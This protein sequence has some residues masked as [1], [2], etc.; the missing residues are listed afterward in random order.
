MSMDI[1]EVPGHDVEKRQFDLQYTPEMLEGV[2]SYVNFLTGAALERL[3]NTDTPLIIRLNNP[4]SESLPGQERGLVVIHSGNVLPIPDNLAPIFKES[5]LYNGKLLHEIEIL[6]DNLPLFNDKIWNFLYPEGLDVNKVQNFKLGTREL[7]FGENEFA[8]LLQIKAVYE[9]AVRNLSNGEL[10]LNTIYITKDGRRAVLVRPRE[11]QLID[12]KIGKRY[13]NDT[14]AMLVDIESGERISEI[15]GKWHM[16][17]WGEQWGTPFS[18]D[19]LLDGPSNSGTIIFQFKIPSELNVTVADFA[20]WDPNLNE[21]GILQASALS[22]LLHSRFPS[23]PDKNSC[24]NELGQEEALIG[25]AVGTNTF[26]PEASYEDTIRICTESAGIAVFNN[27]VGE[28]TKDPTSI[29]KIVDPKLRRNV[30]SAVWYRNQGVE[31]PKSGQMYG[32]VFNYREVDFSSL[33]NNSE[34]KYTED[35][36]R[37]RLEWLPGGEILPGTSPARYYR[38]KIDYHNRKTC[39]TFNFGPKDNVVRFVDLPSDLIPPKIEFKDI[40]SLVDLTTARGTSIVCLMNGEGLPVAKW[41]TD[42]RYWV[43]MEELPGIFIGAKK[44][45]S[46]ITSELIEMFLLQNQTEM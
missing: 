30:L 41:D 6:P 7:P 23:V 8:R 32:V 21:K 5:S 43:P 22:M 3:R 10:T 44:I 13:S 27:F 16:E 35:A 2:K 31:E 1:G 26:V 40:S 25:L 46:Q 15:P 19:P 20:T 24:T 11:C 18:E 12:N 39:L 17:D 28:V 29:E 34:F 42:M 36:F 45:N 33:G 37:K 9:E 4:P 38:S 14:S